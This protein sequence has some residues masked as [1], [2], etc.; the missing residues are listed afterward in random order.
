[1]CQKVI[2]INNCEVSKR[3]VMPERRFSE[4]NTY[5][6]VEFSR[7]ETAPGLYWRDAKYY[8]QFVSVYNPGN[9]M[10]SGI[11]VLLL[12]FGGC[13]PFVFSRRKRQR[14]RDSKKGRLEDGGCS[15]SKASS[16]QT[17]CK[18]QESSLSAPQ[19]QKKPTRTFLSRASH[20]SGPQ[21]LSDED[22]LWLQAFRYGLR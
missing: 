6:R 20:F 21:D 5:F 18:L 17:P 12:L 14:T 3:V 16:D 10:K 13:F 22:K 11:L 8:I 9:I 15:P 4:S 19:K 2:I 7:P 1:M